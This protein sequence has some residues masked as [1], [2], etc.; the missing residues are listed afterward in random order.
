MA[1]RTSAFYQAYRRD[2]E[3]ADY[4]F[5]LAVTLDHLG[6][7]SLTRVYYERA[8]DLTERRKY[9]FDSRAARNS[10][11]TYSAMSTAQKTK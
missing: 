4:A 2:I 5:N 1:N 6:Q 8:L 7:P 11:G 10:F 9:N 3:N